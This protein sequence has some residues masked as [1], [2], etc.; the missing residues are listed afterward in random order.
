MSKNEKKKGLRVWMY[1]LAFIIAFGAGIASKSVSPAWAKEYSVKWSDDIGTLKADIP[2]GN[3]EANKFDLYLPKDSSR[4]NYGL[5]VY[6]HAG[7]FTTG[8]KSDDAEM[9]SWLCSKGYVSAGINYTLRT[10]E[11]NASVY[12][13]SNEI[14][15]AV[16]KVIEAARNEGYEIDRLTM[17]GGSAGHALAMI[18]AYRD[19]KDAPVPVVLTFGAVGPSCFFA[20]DWDNYGLDL[21]TDESRAAAAGLF[22]VMLGEELTAEEIERGSYIEKMKPISAAMWITPDSPPT[23]VAYSTYDKVQPFKAS[24]RLKTA[25]EE[26]GVDF[27]YYELPHSGHGLQNDSDIQRQWMESVEEYLDKYMG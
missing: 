7:G 27:R 22:G 16:P 26:N 19:G 21:N 8:D 13:Q 24:L 9:L 12:T 2:Y 11:N 6:L 1:I 14:K 25:L 15:E 17:S 23:V 18:Y 5:V 4:E 3:G 20:E 10:D